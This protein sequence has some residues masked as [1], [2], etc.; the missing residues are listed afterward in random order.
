MREWKTFSYDKQ[1]LCTTE[2]TKTNYI[3][4]RI[5]SAAD[6]PFYLCSHVLSGLLVGGEGEG[7]QT[8]KPS[9]QNKVGVR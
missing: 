1:N 6:V 7:E 9:G 4:L 2:N 3:P 5:F 8:N